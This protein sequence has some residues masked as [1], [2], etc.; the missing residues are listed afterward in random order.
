MFGREV[1]DGC[2]QV[3]FLNGC[4]TQPQ[5]KGLNAAVGSL[6]ERHPPRHQRC[7]GPNFALQFYE[8]LANSHAEEP[9]ADLPALS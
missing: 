2:L 8:R 5:V 6:G 9:F 3:I 4:S 7:A 1:K